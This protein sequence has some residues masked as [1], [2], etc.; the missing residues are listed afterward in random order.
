[1]QYFIFFIILSIYIGII[2]AK[3]KKMNQ[4]HPL[5][6]IFNFSNFEKNENNDHLISLLIEAGE[7]LTKLIY[8]DN[9]KDIS[10]KMKAKYKINITFNQA[11]DS[12]ADIII[13][14]VLKKMKNEFKIGINQKQ[15][16]KMPSIVNLQVK[17]EIN[18][19]SKDEN[20]R[21]IL[22]LKALRILTD[23]LGLDKNY[24]KKNK[25]YRNNFFQTPYY[26]TEGKEQSFESIKKLYRL[27]GKRVPKKNISLNG[28][29]YIST[30]EKNFIVK[31][32]RSEK[33]DISGDISE[34]SLNMFNDIQFY[35]LSKFDY[36]Y[37]G[38]KKK[39]YRV[40]QKCLNK[41]ELKKYY[42][43]Y[44]INQ[45]K[46]NQIVCYLSN[47]D[48]IKQNKCGTKYSFLIEDK[49]DI[50]PLVSKKNIEAKD[51]KNNMIPDLI[52]YDE[53]TLNLLKPS[54]KCPIPLRTI[55]FKSF[56]KKENLPKKYEV[57]KITLKKKQRK[58]FVSYLTIHEEYYDSYV[59][60]L[61]K[62]GI[63]RS[64]YHNNDQNLYIK[65]FEGSYIKELNK[66]G[67]YF[68]QYQKLY[69]FVGIEEYFCKN[70]LF[71]N[72]ENM[73]NHFPEDYDYMPET[74][75]YPKDA[76]KIKKIFGNYSLNIKDLW[77]VKP[78]AESCGIGIHIF[79]SLE[80]EKKGR[81]KNFIISRYLSSPHLIDKKKYDMRIYVLLTGFQPLRIY[82]YKEGIIRRA[83]EEYKLDIKSLDNKYSHITNTAI[84]QYNKNYKNPKNELDEKAN[85]WNFKTYRRYL[86]RNNIDVNLIF[87]KIKDIVIKTFISGEKK[88]IQATQNYKYNDIYMFNLFG[89]D[90]FIDNEYNSHLIEVNTRPIMKDYNKYEKVLKSSLFVDTLNIVGITPF[91]HDKK[92]ESLDKDLSYKNNYEKRIDDALCEL[93]RPR[94]DY[95][96]IFPLKDNIDK[97]KKYFLKK[98][99]IEN[100]KIWK[101]IKNGF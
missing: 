82:L 9:T 63:I 67:D 47:S 70:L 26:F 74:Y 17:E 48:N 100:T 5:R 38:K 79:K 33:I 61:K 65:K 27:S 28:D 34:S 98:E 64:Y 37:I 59:N 75:D 68:N 101:I 16:N 92:H 21:F 51:I 95:E 80:K 44:G 86:K 22:M 71:K 54:K 23:C 35:S 49:M 52:Y 99:G 53:Q 72:Y 15:K 42:L 43:N 73:R 58:Y 78:K 97:Y 25:F 8:T 93:T 41:T 2:D 36:E 94:G 91:S 81:Y 3:S 90:I 85:E 7:I 45:E 20:S 11:S 89:L 32:F 88:V 4:F 1:M 66:K 39:C 77:I 19:I 40:D 76:K 84:N 14:P 55:Y 30:W 31:D 62:N 6:I 18:F 96:L 46:N 57:E 56:L 24:L 10:Q 83:A 87:D 13:I 50:C 69:H 29:F 12:D 60:L